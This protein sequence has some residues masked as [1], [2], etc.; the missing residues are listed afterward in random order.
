M[1]IET[2]CRFNKTTKL[3]IFDIVIYLLEFMYARNVS[4]SSLIHSSIQIEIVLQRVRI[5]IG[6]PANGVS[7]AGR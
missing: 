3:L 1:K 6:P 4:L 2:I 7:L 5:Q